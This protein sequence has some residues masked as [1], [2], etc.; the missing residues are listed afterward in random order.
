MPA[1][2][3]IHL[4]THSAYS[5]AEGTM[6]PKEL[7]KLV[8][9]QDMPAVAMT[10]TN[11]MF[12]AL[13]FS[14]AATGAG[15][16]PI[17]GCQVSLDSKNGV[18]EQLVFLVQNEVGYRNLSKIISDAY[19]LGEGGKT[20]CTTLKAIAGAHEGLICLSGGTMHG[21][22]QKKQIVKLQEIFGDR[23]YIEIQRH[24]IREEEAREAALID[25]AYELNIPL[26]AT[27]NCFFGSVTMHEAHD[28]L[29]C[30]AE[31]RYVT[32]D[33]RRKETKHHFLKSA[34]QM[35]ELFKDIPEAVQNTVKIARRC[36]FI[37]KAIDPIL[38]PFETESGRNEAQ[39]L[40]AQSKEG[41]QWRIDN[42]YA[43]KEDHTLYWE[44][45]E[46]ELN[47]IEQMGFPGYFL[48]CS[49]F[50][51]WAKDH[52][53]P[54]GPGR[55]SG[56]G[57]VVAWAL[58]ITDLDPLQFNLLFERFLNP[59]RVSMPDF[60]VDFCQ[61]RRGEVI[62]YVQDKYGHDKVA[63]IITFG[64]LQARAVVRDTGRVLQ[65]PYGLV[66]RIAKM[67]PN[68]P[69]APMTLQEALDSDPDLRAEGEK[70]E[71]SAKL[72]NIALKLEG[73]YR[74]ASTHAAGLVIGDRELHKL[75]PVYKD[76]RSDMPVTQ[77]NMKYVEQ[78]GLVKFDFL[79]LKTLTVIQ[80]A[81][82][83]IREHH[84]QEID[85]LTIPLDDR[86]SFEMM[87]R[88]E[89]TGVFQLESAGMK[90]VLRKMKPNRFEDI[91]ALVALYRP[92]PMD[93]IPKYIA[94]K[95]GEEKPDYLHPKLQPILE[96]TF[97]IMIY[98]EQVMQAAQILSGYSLGAADLLRRAMGKKIKEEMDKERV[99]F[100]VGAAEHN[101]VP[102]EQASAIFDQ[103]AKFAGYGFNKSHAAAYALIAYQTAWLK[104]NYPVEFMAASMTLDYGNTDK[105]SVFK[106]EIDR[107]GMTLLPPSVNKSGAMFRVE[108]I[109]GHEKYKSAVRYALAALKGVGEG[110]MQAL[111]DERDARG[112]YK[113]L[114]NL[115]L[116]S[117]SKV[118]SKKQMEGL[119]C[120]GAFD[121]FGMSRA[122]IHGNMEMILR[123]AQSKAE[124]KASGQVSLFGGSDSEE[125]KLPP[126]IKVEP[127]D[128]LELLAREFAA[129]GFYL[130]AHPL[131]T[132][133]DQLEQLGITKFAE[134][135]RALSKK[136]NSR[137]QMA[138]ILIRKQERVSAKSGNKF[139]FLQ[140][141]DATGVFE[142][143]IFS[144]TLARNR[145]I[146]VPGTALMISLDA[147][148]QNEE[149]RFTGQHI[150]VLE[151]ALAAKIRTLGVHIEGSQPI[152]I[153]KRMMD[154]DGAGPVQITVFAHI[155]DD[156]VEIPLKGRWSVPAH[157]LMSLQKT[158]GFLS[159]QE[160]A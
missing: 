115:A 48:I 122:Q 65:M 50:I 30:I 17:I 130:S 153:I 111:V 1:P 100:V 82:S 147:Q 39:E 62:R 68:N 46:F 97:G 114:D 57:S 156:I 106:Q 137:L 84:G 55:G 35:V 32:E 54:V 81:I 138:G 139:A 23:F 33:D 127:W 6:H 134:V 85:A 69:A 58:K 76:P 79:G 5:L 67:I 129:I 36:H 42:G 9:G 31:G 141:S 34:D 131:D 125:E 136:S 149:I 87:A 41:L 72:I 14:M 112:V 45:L 117:D 77:F 152:D 44:R 60:D 78:A 99:K 113:S 126:L 49:D 120:S 86:L 47:V 123:F 104:A 18:G 7:V 19:M 92:G 148:E 21:V 15:L 142:V 11:N 110:A 133:S 2:Q 144:D 3:F 29:L 4:H 40:R 73:L 28:A 105:L 94:T 132:Q 22:T 56:A 107:M 91:I 20:V 27:N 96:E 109:E 121:E 108:P 89:T 16:Q 12:G 59:E 158:P 90:D 93:N 155:A 143:M 26:V 43:S 159:L 71:T 13:E 140:M 103:I 98:Q 10:D 95:N 53:I 145:N 119:I 24:D 150:E 83:L 160:S 74:H 25:L 37:L 75:V 116:R 80:E 101:D 151:D 8:A 52:D 38:P 135:P 118:L 66:D 154:E 70:D 124:E 88:G 128:Q 61:D 63:Q 146:L 51:K 64:K 102:E 157:V